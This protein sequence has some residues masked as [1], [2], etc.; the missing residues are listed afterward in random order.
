MNPRSE[1]ASTARRAVV[2][3]KSAAAGDDRLFHRRVGWRPGAG[4]SKADAIVAGAR[5]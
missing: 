1:R 3:K 5:T 2:G 4:S